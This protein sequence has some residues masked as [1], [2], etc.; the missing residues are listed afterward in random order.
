V[1]S[2]RDRLRALALVMA[3]LAWVA[4][5]IASELEMAG[6]GRQDCRGA[7]IRVLGRPSGRW[8][9]PVAHA[10]SVMAAMPDRDGTA[11]ARVSPS[12]DDLNVQVVLKDGRA[13]NRLVR[14]PEALV[15]TLEA[16]LTLPTLSDAG[17]QAVVADDPSDAPQD[18][19]PAA[20]RFGVEIG[21]GVA[22]RIAGPGS[23]LMASP[24]LFAQVRGGAW[25]AGMGLRWETLERFTGAAPPGFEADA[26]SL[27]LSVARRVH[28]GLSQLDFGVSPRL[29][30]QTQTYQPP[31]GETSGTSTDIR[32]GTFVRAAFG[33]Q[34]VRFLLEVDAEVSPTHL[35]RELRINP[36]LP[37]LA[38]WSAG[39]SMGAV[40]GEQ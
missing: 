15:P 10:C 40:W 30:S 1:R 21:G 6:P 13:T 19:E 3:G 35:R 18:R 28:A 20:P 14:S 4:P 22:G 39:L 5:V 31:G 24:S 7:G 9:A 8:L 38:G 32:T 33:R 25:L 36:A 27:S 29:V 23:Y 2:F 17:L 16:L 26:L 37:R 11:E 12:G 34:P